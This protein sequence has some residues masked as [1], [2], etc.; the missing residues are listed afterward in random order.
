MA[1]PVDGGVAQVVTD[2]VRAQAA[3]GLRTLVLCPPGGELAR[4]AAAAGAEVGLWLAER[5]PGPHLP[6]EA[7]AAG[8]AIR[9]ARPDVVHLH[10]AKAGLAGRLALRGSLPTVFQPHAWSFHAAGGPS[11]ALALRWERL[12]ARWAHRLLCVSE[13]E[14]Q[15]GERARVPGRWAVLPNGVDLTRF[16]LAGRDARARAREAL[17][18]TYALPGHAP[19][20]VCV[21]RLCPQKGQDLLLRAWPSVAARVPGARL[22]LV[23]DGGERAALRRAAGPEVL[24]AGHV[25]DPYPWYA[26]ADLVVL[27]SRWE[28]MALAPLE[29]MAAGRPVLLT[30]VAGALESLP[31]GQERH[32]LVPALDPVALAGA[33]VALLGDPATLRRLGRQAAAHARSVHDVRR[34][35]AG[36]AR[37]YRELLAERAAS[38]PAQAPQAR[39]FSPR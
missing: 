23:G 26:A 12:G 30:D 16:P 31:P 19:L 20:V 2:L 1:Q 13:R 33:L 14:R 27:P 17:A 22:A 4:G 37:L 21:G 24:F 11:A 7:A 15:E 9:R 34:T 18:A 38:P 5:A 29:A 39:E 8:R 3:A 35:A 28:G 10:S 36:C 32:C 25:D 6:W